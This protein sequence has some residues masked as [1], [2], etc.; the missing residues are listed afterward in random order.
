MP[1]EHLPRDV[2]DVAGPA[3]AAQTLDQRSVIAAA[4]EAHL[5]ALARLCG[6]ESRRPRFGPGLRL[7]LAAEREPAPGENLGRHRRQHV[8]LILGRVGSARDQRRPRPLHDLRVV[9]RGDPRRPDRV[10]D[11]RDRREAE[12]TVAPD[13]RV[14]REAGR[15]GAHEVVDDRPPEA[16]AEVD[17]QMG[18]AQRMAGIARG[19]HGL[20]RA[21]RPL[22][23][24]RHRV[25]PQP[26]RHADRSH[27][28]L[29]RLG[30]RHGRVDPAAHGHDDAARDGRQAG[31]APRP[32]RGPSGGRRPR[33]WCT[34]GSRRPSRYA[35]QALRR[36][37]G[38]RR[39]RRGPR[40]A[41]RRARPPRSRAGRRMSGGGRRRSHRRPPGGRCAPHRRTPGCRRRPG[42]HPARR[43]RRG[44][45]RARGRRRLPSTPARRLR[46][47]SVPM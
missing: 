25:D 15:V 2:D 20:W 4:D 10:R 43:R 19:A 12:L 32:R 17:R 18:D 33:A 11:G 13:A 29:H 26:Q 23:V 9:A 38:R 21:A 44:C 46:Q 45:A 24:G 36:P 40:R 35:R 39:A 22:A 14:R 5:L 47:E 31:P 8:R 1:P 37:A 28:R 16:L 27:S 34:R 7:G 3:R 6:R 30:E 41:G 42:R